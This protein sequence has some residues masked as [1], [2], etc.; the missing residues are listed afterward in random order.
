MQILF[1]QW[2][3]L[4]ID[5]VTHNLGSLSQG[6]TVKFNKLRGDKIWT[7][8]VDSLKHTSFWPDT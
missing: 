5:A 4:Q 2:E 8:E 1:L 3:A 6:S 7:R